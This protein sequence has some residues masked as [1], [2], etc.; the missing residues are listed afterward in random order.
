MASGAQFIRSAQL[1]LANSSQALDLS[2]LR[3][4][5]KISAADVETPNTAEIRVYNLSEETIKQAIAEYSS[6]VVGG[7][8]QSNAGTLFKG[9]IKQFWRGKE[10]YVDSFL[11]IMAA[12]GD[13]AYNF[14]AIQQSLPSGSTNQSRFKALVGALGLPSD[15]NAPSYLSSTGGILPR[16]KVLFGLARDYMRDLSTSNDVRWSIQNG[17][18]TLVPL[19]GYLPGEAVQINS[20][21][22]MIGVPRATDQGIEVTCLINPKLRVGGQIQLNNKDITSATIKQQFFPRYT[23]YNLIASIS[24]SDDGFYRIVVIEHEGDTRD[25]EWYTHLICLNVD[26]SSAPDSSVLPFGIPQ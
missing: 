11:D 8:Y 1:L 22:G 10:R 25:T 19:T 12:D 20:A 17:T 23:D 21:T 15:P 7:G 4:R 6:V 24:S 16:G 14:A 2:N 13:T 3:F 26:P 18:V 9:T 5:F